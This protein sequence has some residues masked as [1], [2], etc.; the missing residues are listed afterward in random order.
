MGLKSLI[1]DF[2]KRGERPYGRLLTLSRYTISFDANFFNRV[3]SASGWDVRIHVEENDEDVSPLTDK[4]VFSTLGFEHIESIDYSDYEWPDFIHDLNDTNIPIEL[5]E[6]YDF[7]VDGGTMEHIFN[8]PNVLENVHKMLKVGGTFLFDQPI[9]QGF[10]K[11]YYNCSPC[12]FY[13]YFLI[14]QYKINSFSVYA[15]KDDF[16]YVADSIINDICGEIPLIEGSISSVC[17]SVTKTSN[18][19]CNISPN[20]GSYKKLWERK[21]NLIIDD[22]FNHYDEKSIYLYGTGIFAKNMVSVLPDNHRPKIAGFLSRELNEIGK[23]LHGYKVYSLDEVSNK[24]C[25]IIATSGQFQNIIYN[26]IKHVEEK[27]IRVIK[28]YQ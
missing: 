20:Q 7:I 24:C 18:S 4:I 25:I 21:S 12:L 14:N 23:M 16:Y 3:C 17:G 1:D 22:V 15:R 26:R 5:E 9:W 28:L 27:G 6:Q 8:L 13:E 10:N 11:G 19:S 2:N